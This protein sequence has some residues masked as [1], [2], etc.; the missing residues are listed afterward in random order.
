MASEA[1]RMTNQINLVAA[2]QQEV[3]IG[4]ED[5]PRRAG[6]GHDDPYRV[7][8][9]SPAAMPG[10][11][12]DPGTLRPGAGAGE[13]RELTP[14]EQEAAQERVEETEAA[15]RAAAQSDP[16]RWRSIYAPEPT[17]QTEETVELIWP[18]RST[19]FRIAAARLWQT[20]VEDNLPLPRQLTAQTARLRDRMANEALR[21]ELTAMV[22]TDLRSM[23]LPV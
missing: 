10:D 13:D 14:R 5:P 22:E 16:D 20:R 11:R 6:A 18:E 3:L 2:E 12:V 9:G 19:G 4:V 23:K 17:E 15:E 21:E 8:P 1:E 7:D